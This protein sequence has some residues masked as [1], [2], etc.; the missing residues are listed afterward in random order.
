MAERAEKAAAEVLENL[1]KDVKDNLT[2]N[3]QGE[4]ADHFTEFQMGWLSQYAQYYKLKNPDE[5]IPLP[6]LK[7]W[8][9][10]ASSMR[11]AGATNVPTWMGSSLL[12]LFNAS[13]NEAENPVADWLSGFY[14]TNG[15]Y[16]NDFMSM[17]QGMA[18]IFEATEDVLQ[19]YTNAPE[20]TPSQMEVE[21]VEYNKN[22]KSQE[23]SGV[24]QDQY[25]FTTA[26][27]KA[28]IN[29][30][31]YED[32]A[33]FGR[34]IDNF[35]N[36]FNEQQK[37]NPESDYVKEM[38]SAVEAIIKART[39]NTAD[40][41]LGGNKVA[42]D[43]ILGEQTVEV[44]AKITK[45]DDNGQE[46][47]IEAKATITS[48]EQQEDG[49]YEVTME[50][51]AEDMAAIQAQIEEMGGEVLEI[52]TDGDTTLLK[53]KIDEQNGRQLEE[54]VKGNTDNL[55]SG[56][57]AQDGRSITVVVNYVKGDTSGLEA[58]DQKEG[59]ASG[60]NNSNGNFA[61]GKHL[62]N[63]YQGIA[64]VGE[65][66]PELQIHRGMPFLVGIHGRTK[67]YVEPGDSIFTAAE[68]QKILENNPTLQ[69]I[70]GFSTGYGSGFTFGTS[71]GYGDTGKN[72]KTKEFDPERYHLI[73]RQLADLTRWY[74]RLNKIKEKA[75][76]ANK[77]KAIEE[78]IKATNELIQAQQALIDEAEDYRQKDLQRL[79]DLGIDFEL[80]SHGNLLN[81]EELQEKYGR[82]A[83][84]AEDEDEKKAATDR[85][86]AIQQYEETIDKIHEAE[87]GMADYIMQLS[88]LELE[89]ITVE[90][91][92]KVKYD[93][94]A[95]DYL[96][97]FI[98]KID[99]DIYQ[100]AAVF[101]LVGGQIDATTHKID[102][103]KKGINDIFE[104]L[105]DQEGNKIEGMTLAKFLGLT[106]EE[107]EALKINSDDLEAIDDYLDS[108]MESVEQLEEF[109]YTGVNKIKQAFEELSKNVEKQIDIFDHYKS[110][111]NS[112]KNISDLMG[113]KTTEESKRLTEALLQANNK[114]IKNNIASQQAYYKTLEEQAGKIR[115]LYENT[116]DVG[117]AKKYKEQLE[118][119]EDKMRNTNETILSLWEEGLQAFQEKF[120]NRMEE[121]VKE[122]ENSFSSLGDLGFMEG[123]YNRSK[124]ISNQYVKDYEK[125]YQLS[126]LERDI[127]KTM[128]ELSISTGR[129]NKALAAILKDVNKAQKEGTDMSEYDLEILRK[130]YEIEK[131]RAELEEARNAKSIVRLQRD[132]NGGWGYVYT[133]DQDNI[134]E[135]EQNVE[136]AI[137][138]YQDTNEKYIEEQLNSLFEMAQKIKDEGSDAIAMITSGTKEEAAQGFEQ[139]KSLIK[140]YEKMGNFSI[141][142]LQK[143][144][145]NNNWSLDYALKIY[146][147]KMPDF[148]AF[149][150]LTN[151][152]GETVFSGIA[153]VSTADEWLTKILDGMNQFIAG[154]EDAIA[155]HE[156]GIN[157]I[158]SMIGTSTDTF[159]E[160][161]EGWISEVGAASD[162]TTSSV[163]DAIDEFK[164]QFND[165]TSAAVDFEN[166]YL[167]M[168]HAIVADT[169]EFIVELG[170]AINILGLGVDLMTAYKVGTTSSRI[171]MG[172]NGNTKYN[173]TGTSTLVPLFDGDGGLTGYV[174]RMGTTEKKISV[175]SVGNIIGGE[176]IGIT[177]SHYGTSSIL[178]SINN[179]I[180]NI[181]TILSQIDY[182]VSSMFRGSTLPYL[183]IYD[184]FFKHDDYFQNHGL[185][186]YVQS[187][188][189]NADFPDATNQQEIS[190]A[191]DNLINKASQYANE[192]RNG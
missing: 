52:S 167:D 96:Q 147:D 70:P 11:D 86:K 130:R 53:A 71:G 119:I 14:Y 56:I 151:L 6:S 55:K 21:S 43:Q 13:K 15:E 141:S 58:G 34:A 115:E 185:G 7:T 30:Q 79:K 89:A 144:L 140:D 59:G 48:V 80:D 8:S 62:N 122:Y 92:Y 47:V 82:V 156:E 136:N 35:I 137:H 177:G 142:E 85:W 126:K 87:E 78:E 133:V 12:G 98:D 106:P 118:D 138:D 132:N 190:M 67:T 124:E 66:G 60:F 39:E 174:E 76:G 183:G 45:I 27:L 187:V 188:T 41:S 150:N 18:D 125:Y 42:A 127:N 178:D 77:V 110:V 116:T 186:G 148:G 44:T 46:V 24:F 111:L 171:E 169:E 160:D 123:V 105:H 26:L 63:D 5:Q 172:M 134:D 109:K 28:G 2:G 99:D 40:T 192:K 170:N 168:I 64:T 65:L 131:A 166:T 191:F 121:L 143:A 69:D 19:D 157:D 135:L 4:F 101:Q 74:D 95:L 107:R 113:A 154:A 57:D 149:E 61:G 72:K 25:D 32:G 129:N 163:A 84:E 164:Q 93:E 181:Q 180:Q 102:S 83:T 128:G 1:G 184:N 104:K 37:E 68:T 36:S 153:G 179:G 139:L 33:E 29:P 161:A 10:F 152:F 112:I 22:I 3:G 145:E 90:V 54:L 81:F 159:V 114:N 94:K 117:L 31:N 50:G 88:E 51:S 23:E 97:H 100:T 38:A 108:L 146:K 91:D 103:L 173:T 17:L 73:T 175:D 158:S 165:I 176:I 189:I 16:A 75:F 20:K 162:E 155:E 49:S 182:Q 120:E 9:E